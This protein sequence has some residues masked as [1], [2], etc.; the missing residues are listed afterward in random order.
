MHTNL[1]KEFKGMLLKKENPE[2]EVSLEL[3][4]KV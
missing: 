4:L 3:V 1:L 2:E